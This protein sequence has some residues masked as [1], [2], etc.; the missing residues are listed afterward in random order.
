MKIG[1]R[2]NIQCWYQL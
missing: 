1:N 2:I